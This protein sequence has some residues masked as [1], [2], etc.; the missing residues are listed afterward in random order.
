MMV[1]WSESMSAGTSESMFLRRAQM[2]LQEE[3]PG[4]SSV[5]NV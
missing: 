2:T 4:L 5:V 3:G 1:S